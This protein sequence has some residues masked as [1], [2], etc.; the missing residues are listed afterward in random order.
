MNYHQLPIWRQSQGLLLAVEES[1]R[2]FSR[3]HKYTIGDEL[4][5]TALRLC[6][7]I[8]RAFTRHRSKLKLVQT[9]SE[10]ID[11]LKFQLQLAKELKAF[12]GFAQFQQLTELVVSLGKQAGGWY[13]KTRAEYLQGNSLPDK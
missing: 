13:K 5:Q 4:R 6:K 9:V 12:N 7:A 2:Q 1:V 3:Y 8:H 11:D 10:L